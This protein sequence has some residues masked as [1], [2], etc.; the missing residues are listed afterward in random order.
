MLVFCQDYQGLIPP[1]LLNL[2]GTFVPQFILHAGSA[3]FLCPPL[4]EFLPLLHR[5]FI[6]PRASQLLGF[7]KSVFCG[8]RA[9]YLLFHSLQIVL[10]AFEIGADDA[11][12]RL[13]KRI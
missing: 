7:L 4:P 8:E 3:Q 5:R 1:N 6:C 9:S 2:F 10:P 11:D 12:L 13:A